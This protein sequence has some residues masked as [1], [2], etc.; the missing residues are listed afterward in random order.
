MA[1][2]K[3][4]SNLDAA[5]STTQ[6][7]S[8]NSTKVATT[9]Y[10]TTAIANLSDSAPAAL[11]TLNEIAAALGDDA[12]YA[13]TTT[14]AIAAKLPLAGGTMTGNI[15]SNESTFSIFN[16]DFRLKTSGAE[17]ML[18]AVGNGAVEI[19]HDNATKLATTSSGVT[20]T[21]TLTSTGLNSTSGTLQFAD[22]NA[23]FDSSNSSGY[24]VF[25]HTNGS[26]QIGFARTG[27]S[28]GIGYIG[29]DSTNVFAVWDSSFN[30]K[31]VLTQAGNFGIG[32]IS[33][34]ADSDHHSLVIA[35]RANNGGGLLIF[36]DTAGNEDG[37]IFC[38]DGSL[39]IVADNDN[40]SGS[41]SIRFRV[42]G[43]SEKMRIDSSG[44]VMIGSTNSGVGGTI[45]L[46]V[47]S[48]SSSGGIT[49]WSPTSGTH[50]L[51]FGDGYTGTDR[52]RG[53]VE[54]AH[55]GD[56]MRFATGSTERMR[57]DSS[58]RVLIGQALNIAHPNL[59]DLQVG[60]GSGHSGITV[61]TGTGSYG[62]VSFA[63]GSSGTAQYSGLI[64]YYH[65]DNSMRLYTSAQERMRI[66]DDG[67][68]FDFYSDTANDYTPRI[69]LYSKS[70]GAYCGELNFY[71]K[72][73][74]NEWVAASIFATGG[75]G[76]GTGNPPSGGMRLYVRGAYGSTH[77]INAV[78]IAGDGVV[79]GD[80]NDTS[81]V[82][83]KKDIVSLNASDSLTAIKA[84]NP[85]SFK[86]KLDNEARSG[87]IAQEVET[88][89][90]NDVVGENWRAEVGGTEGDPSSRDEG[91]KGK[92]VNS[93]GILAHAVKVIQEQQTAIED[94]QSRIATLEG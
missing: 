7:A 75:S 22:G 35:G 9:A 41:S 65:N 73:S 83:L 36:E 19:M 89:L 64:E 26:A 80:F 60:N 15:T 79:S 29:A 24:S 62:S 55:N 66:H 27:G 5:V 31:M 52:Y 51:G 30:R 87:F 23:S 13:S 28:T 34:R 72:H 54:Y 94:L 68:D 76:Y 17:T 69:N 71:S 48:T 47:G 78:S 53:Y 40:A 14:A 43:S 33:P 91:S 81:D 1:L 84:L 20:V 18:R 3:V 59:D 16:N 12:N 8:D 42:D 25:S 4:P 37:A 86:W 46:S 85:V 67:R 44:K 92:A 2:T 56:S 49:L 45:D 70:S 74:S 11:N 61:Y 50:S 88:H 21:G 10:V 90:P 93:T 57:I 82:A 38:D 58:G 77:G 32:T 39:T 6:S 63:D